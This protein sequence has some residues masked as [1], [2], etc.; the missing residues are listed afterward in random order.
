MKYLRIRN[1]EKFQ[2]YKNRNPPWIKLYGE[3]WS[4]FAFF[5]LDDASKAHLLGLFVL[6]SKTDNKIPF[7]I[8]WINHEIR[9][10]VDVNIDALLASGFL[11]SDG[12]P[13]SKK[14]ARRKQND[15]LEREG[16]GEKS[17]EEGEGG[18]LALAPPPEPK[19]T[20]GEF[21][22]VR[23]TEK[24]Y[25]KLETTIGA[26]FCAQFITELDLYSRTNPQK[27]AKYSDHY[28]TILNWYRR[29][30]KR[31]EIQAF[32]LPQSSEHGPHDC[33]LCQPRHEWSCN[34]PF[35][36]LHREAMCPEFLRQ[37]GKP[38]ALGASP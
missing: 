15:P 4:D 13:A 9:A 25:G 26:A 22:S 20:L 19:L 8:S 23:L 29:A 12:K 16:E 27:F 6:A 5:K 37:S 34:D 10:T 28:A 17:R 1:F 7:D 18:A 32:S 21:S 35:C 30:V 36:D 3:L 11:E 31:G 33:Q 38:L 14:L 24:E 2:H